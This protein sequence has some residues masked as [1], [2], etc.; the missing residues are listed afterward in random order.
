V[1]PFN[2][3]RQL[4]RRHEVEVLAAAN[5]LDEGDVEA[6]APYCT[7]LDVVAVPP[8]QRVQNCLV[9][10]IRGLPLQG[11]ICRSPELLHR[12]R[13][14]L[15]DARPDVVHVEH[16]RA[17]YTGEAIPPGTP[18]VFDS[19]DCISLLLRR[20]LQGSH[21]LAH[22]LL[23]MVE[24]KR[25]RRYESALM[26]R[27]KY[28][29]ATAPED[30]LELEQ[31]S[32]GANVR[33]VTN[34]VDLDY[35]RPVDHTDAATIVFSGKMSYHANVSAVLYFA[36]HIYPLIRVR[37]TEARLRIVGSNPPPEVRALARDPGIV[38]TGFVS[39]IRE[40]IGAATVAVCPVTVKVGVQNK[41]LEAMAMEIPVVATSLGATGLTAVHGQDLLVADAP[42][43]FAQSVCQVLTDPALGERLGRNGRRYVERQHRW[44]QSVTDLECLYEQAIGRAP[45]G[46]AEVVVMPL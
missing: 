22:R 9:G 30:A 24:L 43:E 40:Q 4:S 7:R 35:F 1:R 25:T 11:A 6:L 16:L 27:F 13:Q 44:E 2:F 31:L 39:D 23:A 32:P 14:R 5:E 18:V 15:A 10:A 34:G 36:R 8:R 41:C 26:R 12:L 3:I 21:S 17:A 29:C 38:V 19:V 42:A 33:V 28:V 45:Q 20:T 37:A 46:L